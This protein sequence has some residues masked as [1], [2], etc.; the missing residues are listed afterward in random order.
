MGE[1]KPGPGR[2]AMGRTG[3]DGA[4]ASLRVPTLWLLRPEDTPAPLSPTPSVWIGPWH[5]A[6]KYQ[7]SLWIDWSRGCPLAE[8]TTNWDSRPVGRSPAF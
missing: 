4:S 2:G 3:A 7:Q 5:G 8:L 1:E 6:G